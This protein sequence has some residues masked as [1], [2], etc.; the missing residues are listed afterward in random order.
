MERK[1][2]IPTID[3][4]PPIILLCFIHCRDV[5]PKRRPTGTPKIRAY[6]SDLTARKTANFSPWQINAL[7]IITT[8]NSEG[9]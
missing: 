3:I 7:E 6:M 2:R 9:W 8:L 1:T 4:H 5:P